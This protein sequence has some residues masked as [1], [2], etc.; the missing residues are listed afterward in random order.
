MGPLASIEHSLMDIRGQEG[1]RY[2]PR[3]TMVWFAS[4]PLSQRVTVRPRP[5]LTSSSNRFVKPRPAKAGHS[6]HSRGTFA[7][8]VFDLLV[9]PRPASGA[10]ARRRAAAGLGVW[11]WY[12]LRRCGVSRPV[13]A[14]PRANKSL[15]L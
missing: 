3:L 1:T 10:R 5:A 11:P 6:R 4:R 8:K 12:G 2:V 15:T 13:T 14:S 7:P 9:E